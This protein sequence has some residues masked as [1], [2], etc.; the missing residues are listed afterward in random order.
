MMQNAVIKRLPLLL[1][2]VGCLSAVASVKTDGRLGCFFIKIV[3]CHFV[4]LQYTTVCR[5]ENDMW[6]RNMLLLENPQFLPKFFET[7]S[8][9]PPHDLVIQTKSQRNW[10]KIVDFLIKAYFWATCHF[11]VRILYKFYTPK[12]I[13]HRNNSFL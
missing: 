6:S 12:L 2:L 1:L 5:P 13:Y 7:W 10:L 11:W 9:G 4:K 8:K 3:N